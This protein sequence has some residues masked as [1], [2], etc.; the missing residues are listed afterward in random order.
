MRNTIKNLTIA[1][2]F[3]FG[4]STVSYT[5]IS[6]AEAA[7]FINAHPAKDLQKVLVYT[8]TGYVSGKFVSDG[9]SFKASTTV[10]K[11]T[12]NC[13]HI[14]DG[15]GKEMYVPYSQIK[16]LGYQPETDKKY[17]NMSINIK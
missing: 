2:F 13:I 1:A 4:I 11:L 14:K 17:S 12:D 5:Q 7:T 16:S 8:F 15:T 10:I 3:A 9:D 6:K